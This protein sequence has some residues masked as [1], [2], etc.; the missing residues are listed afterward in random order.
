VTG[1]A[2]RGGEPGGDGAGV[3][4]GKVGN[5]KRGKKA[6]SGDAGRVP[7]MGGTEKNRELNRSEN[8]KKQNPPPPQSR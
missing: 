5:N 4:L 1:G 7:A 3:R 2:L 8:T 6:G